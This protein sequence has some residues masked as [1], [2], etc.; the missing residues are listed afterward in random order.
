MYLGV[1]TRVAVW[2]VLVA[3]LVGASGLVLLDATQN[4]LERSAQESLVQLAQLERA[5]LVD[6][7]DD[8]RVEVAWTAND[9]A[10]EATYFE[11]S[12][13]SESDVTLADI[14]ST[15]RQFG[16]QFTAFRLIDRE[17]TVLEQTPGLS[18]IHI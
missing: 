1:R 11:E 14:L 8:T 13:G 2:L 17:G 16:Q 7:L 5:R 6:E 18:L 4:R 15:A 10:L 12:P 3:L 9:P